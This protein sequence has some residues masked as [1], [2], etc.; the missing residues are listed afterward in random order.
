MSASENSGVGKGNELGEPTAIACH[1]AS[2][3]IALL[4]S[5]GELLWVNAAQ[6]RLLGY[7]PD[8]FLELRK[9]W[10]NLLHPEDVVSVKSSFDRMKESPVRHIIRY[11]IRHKDGEWISFEQ[12]RDPVF[13]DDGRLSYIVTV[14]R[15]ISEEQAREERIS[16]IEHSL[17]WVFN[18][19][20]SAC[21]CYNKD[22]IILRFN[23]EAEKLYG[24][25]AAEAIG[26]P[27]YEVIAP[28]EEKESSLKI[29]REVFKGRSFRGIEWTDRKKDGGRVTVVSNLFPIKDPSDNVLMC[30]TSNID[31][32]KMKEAEEALRVSEEKYRT[33]IENIQD[34]AF[35][36]QDGLLIFVNEAF[37]R[38]AGYEVRELEG[39]EFVNLVAPDDREFVVERYTARLRGE[40]VPSEYEFDLLHKD[41]ETVISVNMNVGMIEYRD[42]IASIG[43]VKDITSQKQSEQNLRD[44]EERFR[45]LSEAS[46]E[47]IVIHEMGRILDLNERF[48]EMFGYEPSELIGS[49]VYDLAAPDSREQVMKN[50]MSSYGEEY[51]ATAI[52][53][54]GTEFDVEIRG[55][56]FPYKGKVVSITSMRDITSQKRM[57]SELEKSESRFRTVADSLG[58]G[59]MITEIETSEFTYVNSRL[60]E[61]TGYAPGEMLGKRS[62]ELLLPEEDWSKI[63]ER[64][65]DRKKGISETYEIKLRRKD[66]VYFWTAITA[67][68]FRDTDGEIIGT[69]GIVK[70]IT[71]SRKAESALRASEEK[72]RVLSDEISDGVAIA[73][74][75]RNY[76]VNKAFCELLGYS[77][78]ELIGREIDFFIVPEDIAAVKSLI[79]ARR[80][81]GSGPSKC[82]ARARTKDGVVLHVEVSA[83]KLVFE[84]EEAIQLILRDVTESR[85]AEEALKK[86]ESQY[87]SLVESTN[88]IPWEVDL[89]TGLFTYVGPQAEEMLGYP[90]ELWTDLE[91]RESIIHANDR[92][93]IRNISLLKSLE[94]ADSE[95]EYRIIAADGRTVW[96]RDLL[97]VEHKDGKPSVLRGFMFDITEKK[98]AMLLQTALM[99]ISEAASIPVELDDMFRIVHANLNLVISASNFYIALFD[100]ETGVYSIPYGVD[101]Y[102][103]HSDFTQDDL[104]RG[105]TDYVRRTGKPLFVDNRTHAELKREGEADLVGSP[106]I[107]WLGVPIKI[108]AGVVGVMAVQTYTDEKLYD[109]TDLELLSIIAGHVAQ[110]IQNARSMDAL[111]ASE[112]KFRTLAENVPGVIYLCRNDERY[113]M[114]YMNDKVLDITGYRKDDF[115]EDEVSIAELFHPDDADDI[116]DIVSAALNARREF[117]SVCRLKHRSG[118]WRWIEIFGEGVFDGDELLYIEGFFYD[119]TDRKYAEMAL[120]ESRKW[121]STTLRSIGDAVITTDEK[122]LVTFMNPVAEQL[123]GSSLG[124]VKG[125]HIDTVF[126]VINEETG[127]LTENPVDKVI[128][129]G[130]I[131]GLANNTALI[132]KDGARI[133][134]DDS[135]APIRDEAGNIIGT[136]LVFHDVTER[137]KA[138]RA[139]MESESRLRTMTDAVDAY[140]W[141]AKVFGSMND[142]E[143]EYLLYTSGVEKISGI[144]R[145]E[146]LKKKDVWVKLIHPD[147]LPLVFDAWQKLAGG[148]LVSEAYR[149]VRPDGEVRW[150]QDSCTPTL[151]NDGRLIRLDG[152][153]IDITER[154]AVTEA[155]SE[156]EERYRLLAENSRLGIYIVQDGVYKFV[157]PAL[158][159]IFGYSADEL[160]DGMS[161]TDLT[162]PE[163]R[164][165]VRKNIEKR[166]SGEIDSLYYAA[167]GMKK[168]G[169]QVDV[170]IW[171]ATIEYK[172]RQAILG[173]LRDITDAKRME[174][175]LRQAQ[176]MEALG[177]L[178]GNMAHYFNNLFTVIMGYGELLMADEADLGKMS[179]LMEIANAAK[180]ATEVA[181]DLLSFSRKQVLKVEPL[182]INKAINESLKPLKQLVP[183]NIRVK[184]RFA[185]NLSLVIADFAQFQQVVFNLVLNS[186]EAMPK[187]GTVTIETSN[188]TLNE[189]YA[190]NY[191]GTEPGEYV[192]ISVTDT[193][194]GIPK[195]HIESIFQPFFT[196]KDRKKSSG[197]GLAMV[198]GFI[199]QIGGHTH[200][201]SEEGHGATIKIYLPA[202][203]EDKASKKPAL[204]EKEALQGT[205][206]VLVVDDDKAIRELATRSLEKYGYSVIC[207]ED[208]RSALEMIERDKP[209]IDIVV[210]DV[211]MPEMGGPELA[212]ELEERMPGLPVLFIS[213]YAENAIVE[214]GV[215]KEGINFLGKPYSPADLCRA[216]RRILDE[217]GEQG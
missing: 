145:D 124:E 194:V 53:K 104:K 39:N 115:L 185:K 169:S 140:L 190:T 205:E 172:G 37:A 68:P 2:D 63:F 213:G 156:S 122:G 110:A 11:R 50:M 48:A 76:W 141:S 165:K 3:I 64:D 217:R 133:P 16:D 199:R 4:D 173:S 45:R 84:K 181:S 191:P 117:H 130:K 151:D 150:V 192:Q 155:L 135:G 204:I 128:G 103:R 36:I 188:I 13:D 35:V 215:L 183:A 148:E 94:G 56:L 167:K 95:I 152:V 109:E 202:S 178:S 31:I 9:N 70:D 211:V 111:K 6:E 81:G 142:G 195:E 49:L 97:S 87:R 198:Y 174:D 146:F 209:D 61:M 89:E 7:T 67:T 51:E 102:D 112:G 157:N 92:E 88:A 34:G 32:S 47:G 207:A 38:M 42:G 170:E 17:Q 197:L 58:E 116:R 123:T 82:E 187:G 125:N 118:E 24:Y 79:A 26:K 159:E 55:K 93:S 86:S 134:I 23:T 154:I 100:E 179:S 138:R 25:T 176:K 177:A 15:P 54:D 143:Y 69:L 20:P 5:D 52:K 212:R 161:P 162:M 60:A 74:E 30:V 1:G 19:I 66:G 77:R 10:E 132:S 163:E 206:A 158:T 12:S 43:T 201:Y 147:D 105:L 27:V 208:G 139:L 80:T 164:N 8:E 200:V 22:G 72:F 189:E 137:R 40:D 14:A 153:C 85:E 214:H 73:I 216:V 98:K 78:G 175:A 114:L 168:D 107:I 91:F 28:P 106:S 160:I 193:G 149:I 101:E 71:E 44:S 171:T 129:E 119:I 21:I 29:I 180:N 166:L 46:Q 186:W 136:V 62:Y 184:K 41:G 121:L 210:A 126:R 113:T 90:S 144:P 75:G 65:Q 127:A 203:K 59:L 18:Q 182:D 196:T 131:I 33:L 83:K 96:V 108:E 120:D 99:H 57:I